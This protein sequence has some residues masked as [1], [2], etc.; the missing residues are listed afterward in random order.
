MLYGAMAADT[1][2]TTYEL[3]TGGKTLSNIT[4]CDAAVVKA[5]SDGAIALAGAGAEAPVGGSTAVKVLNTAAVGKAVHSD[6]SYVTEE[7]C[8]VACT[9]Y[10]TGC[11]HVT[12]SA[13]SRSDRAMHR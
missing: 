3:H 5:V 13:S 4:G 1:C 8:L 11:T 10:I 9:E 2:G 12:I 7:E 6:L